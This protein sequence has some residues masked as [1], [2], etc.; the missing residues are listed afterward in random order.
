[1][2]YLLYCR[3]L[4]LGNGREAPEGFVTVPDM[5]VKAKFLYMYLQLHYVSVKHNTD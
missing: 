3:G 5:Y 4:K 2:L 1:M